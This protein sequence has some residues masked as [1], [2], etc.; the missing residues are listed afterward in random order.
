MS[1]F[2][3]L[4]SFLINGT[5]FTACNA[6]VLAP[7]STRAFIA[8]IPKSGKEHHSSDPKMILFCGICTKL[9]LIVESTIF[10]ILI[11][12]INVI[13]KLIMV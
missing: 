12:P 6:E 5:I 9:K 1:N 2:T 7:E 3:Q 8:G 10:F 4:V 13:F 11:N